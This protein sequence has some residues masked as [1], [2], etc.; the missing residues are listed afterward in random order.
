[1]DATDK[2]IAEVRAVRE[3]DEEMLRSGVLNDTLTIRNMM[4]ISAAFAAGWVSGR[5]Y[6]LSVNAPR[7]PFAEK[8]T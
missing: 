8:A 2:A 1:M 7:S 5:D 4:D 3:S 6:G